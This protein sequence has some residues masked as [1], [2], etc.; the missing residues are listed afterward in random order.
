[1]P[2]ENADLDAQQYLVQARDAFAHDEPAQAEHAIDAAIDVLYFNVLRPDL[3][4][5]LVSLIDDFDPG[6]LLYE[7]EDRE[8]ASFSADCRPDILLAELD[9]I[10]ARHG[11]EIAHS[12]G[13]VQAADL[14]TKVLLERRLERMQAGEQIALPNG[15]LVAGDE[16][17]YL[18]DTMH[19]GLDADVAAIIATGRDGARTRPSSASPAASATDA[20]DVAALCQARPARDAA[21]VAVDPGPSAVHA[22]RAQ[23]R[24]VDRGAGR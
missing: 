18:V 13:P 20:R 12:A 5:E 4:A 7:L 8:L 17:G 10:A 1:M 15:T 6:R 2:G 14:S 21:A 16:R 3:V 23:A 9:D 19:V 11:I 22:A 24:P